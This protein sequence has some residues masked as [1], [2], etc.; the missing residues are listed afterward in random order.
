MSRELYLDSNLVGLA[1][2]SLGTQVQT[3]FQQLEDQF[4]GQAD[5]PIGAP[6][7]GDLPGGSLHALAGPEGAGFMTPEQAIKANQFLGETVTAAP[8]SLTEYPNDGDYGFHTDTGGG[9][10][11]FVKNKGGVLFSATLT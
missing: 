10:Y 4:N 7:H 1:P 9:T 2:E 6:A 5:T 3:V 11:K 8:A